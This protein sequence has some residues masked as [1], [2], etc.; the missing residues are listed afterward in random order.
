MKIWCVLEHHCI[1]QRWSLRKIWSLFAGRHLWSYCFQR[2]NPAK[3]LV[4]KKCGHLAKIEP[5]LHPFCT[6]MGDGGLRW[7][8][9]KRSASVPHFSPFLHSNV[10]KLHECL[11]K[12][13]FYSNGFSSSRTY[14]C[15]LEWINYLKILSHVMS[16]ALKTHTD[17]Q[18]WIEPSFRRT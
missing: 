13:I 5:W 11:S 17:N 12:I 18:H 16:T 8:F 14:V 4:G 10:R 15:V 3:K 1:H 7:M 6:R 2:L 9:N